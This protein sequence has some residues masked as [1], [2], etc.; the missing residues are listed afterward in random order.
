MLKSKD[1][2]S[3]LKAMCFILWRSFRI[4]LQVTRFTSRNIFNGIL[5]LIIQHRRKRKT[6]VI[7]QHVD[8]MQ[9]LRNGMD[10]ISANSVISTQT[11]DMRFSP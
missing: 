3:L 6:R 2:V 5:I 1:A 9:N 11:N 7:L 4:L 8:E 10:Q